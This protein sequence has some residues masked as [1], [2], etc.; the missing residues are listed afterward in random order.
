[1]CAARSMRLPPASGISPLSVSGQ[2]LVSGDAPYRHDR[3][4]G[5]MDVRE[6]TGMMHRVAC[7][8]RFLVALGDDDADIP[9][10]APSVGGVGDSYDKCLG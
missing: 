9:R 8:K 5:P 6:L 7:D 4:L 1:M 10:R 2:G 3:H